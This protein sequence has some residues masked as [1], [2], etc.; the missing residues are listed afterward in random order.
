MLH[1][2]YTLRL[3]IYSYLLFFMVYAFIGWIIEVLYRSYNQKKFVN[4]GF[5][6]GFFV[7]LYGFAGIS[8]VSFDKVIVDENVFLKL[9]L[10]GTIVTVI[11]YLTGYLSEKLFKLKLW[12][13]SD[14]KFNLHGRICLSFSILWAIFTIIFIYFIHPVVLNVIVGLNE[15]ILSISAIIV[16]IY[17]NADFILSVAAVFNFTK[18]LEKLYAD[19]SLFDQNEID[20]LFKSFKRIL[21]AFPRLRGY[22]F[23]NIQ[24]GLKSRIDS[25]VKK[26]DV[27]I[28]DSFHSEE[29]D[30][31]EYY[32]IIKEI[33]EHKEFL[34][35]KNY[36]HHNSSIFEHVKKVSYLSYLLC[37]FLKFDYISAARA[38]L[39]HDFFLYD[40][41]NHDLPDLAKE[42]FHGLHH[43]AIALENSRKYFEVNDIESDI[44]LKH[45]WPLTLIP[46]KYKE[47]IIVSIADKYISSEEFA[48]SFK[49]KIKVKI[50]RTADSE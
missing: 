19:F 16:V 30:E 24:A 45:M 22:L 14:S 2:F 15:S 17:F 23:E 29:Q 34:K 12:D 21:M 42:K 13:Y 1:L 35:L 46:P 43:P 50:K 31:E 38:G 9:F 4:A 3:D 37:K 39:L 6:H 25:I 8:I 33:I 44:I 47:S 20:I 18:K 36:Y 7:P 27:T 11:E 26:V 28:K 41:R 5:L 40:W 48:Q 49:E 32:G 10:F